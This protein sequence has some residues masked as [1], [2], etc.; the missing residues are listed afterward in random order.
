MAEYDRILTLHPEG[1]KGVRISVQKYEM[2]KEAIISI[3]EEK[4]ETR[5][6]ELGPLVKERL[7]GRFDGAV[8]WYFTTLK[9]DLQTR[10]IINVT[11]KDGNQVIIL[12]K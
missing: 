3:L 12:S 5:W 7:E 8:M 2:M 9:L 1:K 4:G 6:K 10:G 11:V